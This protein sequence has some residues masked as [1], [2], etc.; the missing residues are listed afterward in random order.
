MQA[1][2]LLHPNFKRPFIVETDAFDTATRDILSQ[3]RDDGH[4]H[5]CAYH[6]SKMSPVKQNYDIY[7]KEL[8]SIVLTF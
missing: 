3:H 2:V 6:S 7:D 5:P 4:L 8:L 1:L